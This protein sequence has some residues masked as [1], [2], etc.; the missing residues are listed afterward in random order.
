V[1]KSLNIH[2]GRRGKSVRV[3]SLN[4]HHPF[5]FKG[6]LEL[7]GR[8]PTLPSSNILR[9]PRASSHLVRVGTG[10]EHDHHRPTPLADQYRSTRTGRAPCASRQT[11]VWPGA[12]H[13][14]FVIFVGG[15]KFENSYYSITG[16]LRAT[17]RFSLTEDL[18]TRKPSLIPTS[19]LNLSI[20]C[21][22]LS[23]EEGDMFKG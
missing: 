21:H 17:M 4:H 15:K 23:S 2:L 7:G 16:R 19:L 10:R 22:G 6:G 11:G 8:T 13:L 20:R 3:G 18:S 1:N 14:R 5:S 9:V 12:R